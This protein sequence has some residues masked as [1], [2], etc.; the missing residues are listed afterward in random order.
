MKLSQKEHFHLKMKKRFL[1][2][3]Q[4]PRALTLSHFN[5]QSVILENI[6]KNL[7]CLNE[8]YDVFGPIVGKEVNELLKTEKCGNG[9]QWIRKAHK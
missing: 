8:N 6:S 1:K 4:N 3:S 2:F 7:I 9:L 5:Q